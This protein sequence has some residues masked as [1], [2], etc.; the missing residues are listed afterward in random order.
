MSTRF[1][2]IKDMDALVNLL[3]EYGCRGDFFIQ[4]NGGARSSKHIRY[5]HWRETFHVTNEIDGSKQVL[6]AD[7]L[8]D[9]KITNIGAAI[10]AGA[11][12][13]RAP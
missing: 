12:Y 4:L 8:M 2:Q 5:D 3:G 13:H 11:F 10:R 9:S 1:T 7:E 6:T